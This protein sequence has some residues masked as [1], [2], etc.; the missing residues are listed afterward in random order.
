MAGQDLPQSLV[1]WQCVGCGSMGN[2]EPCTGTC[3]F[4]RLTVVAVEDHAELLDFC[5]TLSNQL[6]ALRE[7][8]RD[9]AL[10]SEGPESFSAALETLRF[11]ARK[12][13]RASSA[14][15][16]P[17]AAAGPDNRL[18]VWQCATCGQAEAQHQ[19]L[20]ICIRRNAEFIRA[21]DHDALRARMEEARS[22]MQKL[23]SL[24]R[25]VGWSLPRPGQSE[26]M[27]DALLTLAR[28]A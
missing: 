4:Q 2:S 23:A 26:R 14:T 27:R 10:A 24:A 7:L 16:D 28:A 22:E 6:A 11:R 1:F 25:Q 8:A 13:L 3:D 9:V 20:G 15:Q 19:C 17:P 18:E 12:T 5:L 21:E